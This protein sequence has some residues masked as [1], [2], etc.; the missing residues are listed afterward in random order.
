MET[1]NRKRSRILRKPATVCWERSLR[2]GR[3]RIPAWI[4]PTRSLPRSWEQIPFTVELSCEN[5]KQL[6]GTVPRSCTIPSSNGLLGTVAPFKQ[7]KNPRM[8]RSHSVA[9]PQLGTDPVYCGTV[10]RELETANRNHPS[11]MHN[12]IFQRFAGNGRSVQADQESPHESLPLGCFPAV[13]NRSR[14]LWNCPARI[15]DS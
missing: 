7:T 2:S 3:P 15:G 1:A 10:L 8:N 13:G 14:L 9:S 6:I 11:F 4:A 5:W 12:H